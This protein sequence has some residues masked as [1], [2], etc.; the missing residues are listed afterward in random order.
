MECDDGDGPLN[1][2]LINHGIIESVARLL[3]IYPGAPVKGKDKPLSD[4]FTI[5]V[6]KIDAFP[7]YPGVTESFRSLNLLWAID[8][9]GHSNSVYLLQTVLPRSLVSHSVLSAIQKSTPQNE[10]LFYLDAFPDQQPLAAW[11]T[12]NS[13]ATAHNAVYQACTR[14]DTSQLEAAITWRYVFQRAGRLASQ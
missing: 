11:K 7:S 5:L 6:N 12:F 2:A 4:L 9:F 3:C 13:M 14:G 8:L 1:R 10:A